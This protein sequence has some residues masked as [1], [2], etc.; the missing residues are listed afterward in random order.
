MP[1][2]L[3]ATVVFLSVPIPSP[4]FLY[5]LLPSP[6]IAAQMQLTVLIAAVAAA[7]AQPMQHTC[8]DPS[9]GP[10]LGGVDVVGTFESPT[11]PPVRGN[12]TFVQLF[13]AGQPGRVQGE[14]FQVHPF[15]R[16]LLSLGRRWPRVTDGERRH[17][18][19]LHRGGFLL[20]SACAEAFLVLQLRSQV[21]HAAGVLHVRRQELARHPEHVGGQAVRA[22]LLQ[23]KLHRVS[24][25]SWLA[26]RAGAVS[27]PLVLHSNAARAMQ[28]PTALCCARAQ[29]QIHSDLSS[30]IMTPHPAKC[31]HAERVQLTRTTEA[32]V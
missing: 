10:V 29:L 13:D 30:N 22:L 31:K 21:Q 14:L 26:P 25:S 1:V 20:P 12:S 15:V 17:L 9:D 5:L 18:E 8:G 28:Q 24:T 16:R 7:A 19:S 4:L 3:P 27:R 2:Y 6:K 23:H 32:T 11:A